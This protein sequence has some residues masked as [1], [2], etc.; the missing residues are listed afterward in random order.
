MKNLFWCIPILVLSSCLKYEEPTLLSLNGEYVID[1]IIYH[2][3]KDEQFDIG[4]TY[5]NP[6]EVLPMDT[7]YVGETRWHFDYSVISFSP[8]LNSDG[9]TSWLEQCFYQ[10]SWHYTTYDLGYLEFTCRERR[11]VFKILEDNTESIV[12]RSTNGVFGNNSE[13]LTLYLNRIG[14]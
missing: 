3:N 12:L 9:T 6:L 13:Y 14:P 10:I 1:K 7:I 2:T 11:R 4:E 5:I 8:K